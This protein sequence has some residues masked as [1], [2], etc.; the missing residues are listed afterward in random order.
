MNTYTTGDQGR[1]SVSVSP[2]GGFVVAWTSQYGDGSAMAS[3]ASASTP[4]GNALGDE[5]VVNTY[6]TGHAV[7]PSRQVAHDARGNF[8]VTW[9][10]ARPDGSAYG[11]FAQRFGARAPAAAPSSW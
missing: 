11:V 5:F 8:V 6:T 7:R 2:A 1:P 9:L 4:S 10:S 3:F